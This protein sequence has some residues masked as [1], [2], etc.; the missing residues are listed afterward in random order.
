[1]GSSFQKR[2]LR[3]TFQLATGALNKTGNPDKVVLEDFRAQV[4]IDAPGG[5]QYATCRAAIYGITKETMDRLT[6]INYQNLDFMRN[7]MMIEATDDNGQF[8]VVFLGEVYQ[9][10]PDYNSMPNVA[11]NV[12]A[13]S[14]L[15]GKLSPAV[16]TTYPGPRKV[17]AIM[18]ELAKNM[19]LYFE[20]ND[21][22]TTIVDQVLTGSNL[23]K[24]QKLAEVSNVQ[25]WYLPEENTL[26]ISPFGQPRKSTAFKYNTNSGL[27]GMPTKLHVGIVFDAL[28]K[29]EVRHGFKI[30][31]ESTVPSCNGEW[32][33][34]S[35]SHMLSCETPGGPW[36]SKI[37]ATPANT[38]IRTR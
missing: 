11:L 15:I 17:S 30:Q 25:L 28:Y 20:N 10:I 38:F 1:M 32:Y 8:S 7:T 23:E 35:M 12:D 22:Q 29:A 33:I 13:F 2:R 21:V 16:A 3:I 6:V 19:G 18:Q 4:Q 37:V 24:A 36:F 9:A 27:V 26:A 34:I 5:Y 14:G 31:M